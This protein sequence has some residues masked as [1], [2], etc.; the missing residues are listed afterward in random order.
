M[1]H[2]WER[3][4][5]GREADSTFSFLQLRRLRDVR[6]GMRGS[7]TAG[8]RRNTPRDDLEVVDGTRH[9]SESHG[10]GNKV[11]V[12]FC[13]LAVRLLEGTGAGGG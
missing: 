3:R 12:G 1:A 2:I 10:A 5:V 11:P 4:P 8:K 6:S 9:A 7:V 13:E